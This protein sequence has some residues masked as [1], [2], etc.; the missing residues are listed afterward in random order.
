MFSVVLLL[1]WCEYSCDVYLGSLH[2][3]HANLTINM[4]GATALLTF[5]CVLC[6]LR[7]RMNLTIN[8]HFVSLRLSPFL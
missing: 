8:M 4:G 6:T 2:S 7:T 1:R 3:A 5:I